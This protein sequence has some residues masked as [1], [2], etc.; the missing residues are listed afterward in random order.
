MLFLLFI[1]FSS[2]NLMRITLKEKYDNDDCSAL[3]KKCQCIEDNNGIAHCG[4]IKDSVVYACK[5]ECCY[6]KCNIYNTETPFNKKYVVIKDK[7]N[8]FT[9]KEK[10]RN[11]K[12]LEKEIH[13][14]SQPPNYKGWIKKD[15]IPCWGC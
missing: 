13:C 11:V 5:P 4:F 1:I 14:K 10:R 7:Y 6:Q 8:S 15:K 3:P 9:K 2:S 12:L